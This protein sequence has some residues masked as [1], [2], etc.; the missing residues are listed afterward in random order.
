MSTAFDHSQMDIKPRNEDFQINADMPREWL[1]DDAAVTYWFNAMS[2]VFPEGERLFMDSVR[3]YK[4]QID[5]PKLLEQVRGF[6][7]QEAIHGREHEVYNEVLEEQGLNAA[8]LERLTKI[9]MGYARKQP[10][11]AQLAGT[12]AAE[13][14]TAV[15][16]HALL[17]RPEIMDNAHPTYRAI[18]TWHAIEELEHKAV[19]YDVYETVAG[20]GFGAYMRRVI[21]FT[22]AMSMMNVRFTYNWSVMMRAAGHGIGLRNWGKLFGFLWGK[23]GFYRKAMPHFLSFYGRNFHPWDENDY[24]LATHA[25]N[26]YRADADAGKTGAADAAVGELAAIPAE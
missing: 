14:F 1:N 9:I 12:V 10:K 8:K 22:L 4:D 13:H 26:A 20:K 11:I 17:S 7:A 16:A 25:L 19:A 21:T 2:V 6:V 24:H 18:W 23:T 3:A 5:D 15:M